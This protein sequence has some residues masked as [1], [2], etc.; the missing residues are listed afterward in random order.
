VPRALEKA[1]R[2]IDAGLRELSGARNQP[3]ERILERTAPL[4]LFRVAATR[5]PSLRTP[6]SYLE[7]ES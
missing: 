4:D 1:V 7:P 5:D 3:P 2:G 6:A